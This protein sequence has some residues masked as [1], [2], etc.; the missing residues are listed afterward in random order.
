[1]K[2]V[3]LLFLGMVMFNA[4]C[5]KDNEP[6]VVTVTLNSE[7]NEFIWEGMNYWYFWQADQ[8]D[9]A[10]TR[11]KTTDDFNKYLNSY[12]SPEDLFNDL[13][14]QPGVTDDFS[15]Y[16]PDV[17]EQLNS[18]N[19]IKES[20][21]I[22]FPRRLIR[23]NPD[24]E[25][26]VIFIA[27]VVAGSPADIAGLKR[28]DII[29]RVDGVTMNVD[30]ASIINKV[31]SE[32]SISLGLAN[33]E[34]GNVTSIEGEINLN[35]V[36]IPVSPIQHFQVIQEGGKKIGYLVYNGF[37]RTYNGELNDVFNSFKSENITELILDL[38]YNGGG[39]VLTS[40]F[41]ASM[42]NG[43]VP[44]NSQ[45]FA[46]LQYNAKRDGNNGVNFPFFNE[47]Y[48][49]DKK[50]GDNTGQ[51]PSNRIKSL[52][53]LYVITGQGTASA[54]EMIINGLRP[55]MEVILV[56]EKTV[57]KNEGSITVVDSPSPYT[58]LDNRNKN[59]TIGMQPIVFQVFNSKDQSD[60]TFGFDPEF[61]VEEFRFVS[62][63]K[64]FGDPNEA[65]LRATLDVILGASSKKG[66]LEPNMK[67]FKTE[68]EIS[69]PKFNYD[70]Y[71]LPQEQQ[72]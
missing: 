25:D 3:Y 14:Y 16:I 56:G 30:N 12:N 66:T 15:W 63:I 65:L 48:L 7:V 42:I 45:T 21:G 46:R 5:S 40:A 6:E 34:N 27:Y 8:P 19:G 4:S 44:A 13:V 49:Y 72:N 67:M 35:A 43:N 62:D 52:T 36:V 64:P 59:H 58:N 47:V 23:P 55:Y 32:K 39:S 9:L 22:G 54:S 57:G 53:K 17:D 20:Y 31:F 41:L 10:D 68:K 37:T 29:N 69:F 71:L 26:I 1:M 51:V 2:K 33:I 28:G 24:T 38:R 11:F 60:Y 50:S 61:L 18:F 70:M